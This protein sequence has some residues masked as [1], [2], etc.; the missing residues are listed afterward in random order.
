MWSIQFYNAAEKNEHPE[1]VKLYSA[2]STD[3]SSQLSQDGAKEDHKRF[4]DTSEEGKN[5]LQEEDG[6]LNTSN[7]KEAALNEAEVSPGSLDRS[8]SAGSNKTMDSFIIVD[9]RDAQ[10]EP[11]SRKGKVYPNYCIILFH[12]K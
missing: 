3:S 7:E 2:A 11:A 6:R 12:C 4:G 1:K 5:S 10:E 9:H 8:S